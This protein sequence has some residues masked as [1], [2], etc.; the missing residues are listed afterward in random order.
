VTDEITLAEAQAADQG[1]PTEPTEEV[2]SEQEDPRL[3]KVPGDLRGYVS[4]FWHDL[5][6]YQCNKHKGF[7]TVDPATFRLHLE[8]THALDWLE[9]V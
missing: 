8:K 7:K 9:G 4:S 3:A 6:N 5:P 1:L 2:E